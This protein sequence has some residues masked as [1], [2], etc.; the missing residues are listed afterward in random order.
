MLLYISDV[1]TFEMVG[2]DFMKDHFVEVDTRG[3]QRSMTSFVTAR[4]WLL[5]LKIQ[6][7]KK[8]LLKEPEDKTFTRDADA[9]DLV[10]SC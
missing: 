6:Q 3:S 8:I 7:D 4:P 1:P 2:G 10:S 9:F 5:Q